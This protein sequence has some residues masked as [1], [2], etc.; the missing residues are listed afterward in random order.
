MFARSRNSC[1]WLKITFSKTVEI[2]ESLKIGL[3]LERTKGSKCFLF[4]KGCTVACLKEAGIRPELRH[5]FIRNK[6]KGPTELKTFLNKWDGMLSDGQLAEI[7]NNIIYFQ[8]NGYKLP[9][10]VTTVYTPWFSVE[11]RFVCHLCV[12]EKRVVGLVMVSLL[13]GIY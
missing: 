2:N 6:I 4:K 8:N 10:M 1:S 12:V 5:R 11:D 7:M 9:S 3:K 13:W